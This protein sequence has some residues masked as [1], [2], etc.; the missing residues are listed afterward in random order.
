MVAARPAAT[1]VAAAAAAACCPSCL[2]EAAALRSRL[3]S[4]CSGPHSPAFQQHYA[5]QRSPF[6][7]EQRRR[8]GQRCRLDYLQRH[9]H[10]MVVI[11]IPSA[12]PRH[13]IITVSAQR[14]PSAGIFITPHRPQIE[15]REIQVLQTRVHCAR[16]GMTGNSILAPNRSAGTSWTDWAQ[17]LTGESTAP[18]NL[19]NAHESRGDLD[20]LCSCRCTGSAPARAYVPYTQ[21]CY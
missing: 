4:S 21:W 10:G 5:A 16:L 20:H 19:R 11:I 8:Q 6:Q 2:P 9:P 14:S 12:S 13:R 18:S 1:A 15:I 3:P 17:I 7:P